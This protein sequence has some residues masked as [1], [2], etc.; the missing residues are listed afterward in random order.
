MSVYLFIGNVLICSS[1]Y[2][3]TNFSVHSL[4]TRQK[5]HLHKPLVKFAL[6]QSGIT[7]SP[8]NVFNKLPL[9][10]T[11]FQHDKMQFKTAL[12]KYLLTNVFH[13]VDE[14]LAFW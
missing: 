10:I 2:F 4:H 8:I 11:Q 5:N 9:D 3:K 7:Y 14:F 6:I 13:S 1:C 12:K